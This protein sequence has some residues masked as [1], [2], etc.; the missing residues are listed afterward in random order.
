MPPLISCQTL[1]KSFGARALFTDI[2]FGVSEDEKLGLIGPNGSGKSTM[3]RLLAGEDKPD[4]GEMT[5][6]RGLRLVYVAQEDKFNLDATVDEIL[7]DAMKDD[8]LEDYE[9]D[10]QRNMAL[11]SAGF[12]SGE[13][14]VGTLSGGWKKRLSLARA[15]VQRPDLLLLDEPTNHLDLQG[16][17][18]L[19]NLLKTA[20]FAFILVSHDRYFL[21]NVTN[22]IVEL[23]RAYPEGYLSVNGNYSEFL[24]QK[25]DFLAVQQHRQHALEG[26]V[27]RE[28]DWLRRGP[29]ARTTKAQY[30]IDAA[31]QLIGELAEVKYRNAQDK[32][33]T[34]D[35]SAS[36]RK[37]RE[38][39]VAKKIAKTLGGRTLFSDVDI[40]LMPGSKL[41]L[42][43]ANGSGKTTLIK[44]LTGGME[45][46]A[47]TIKRADGLR[48]VLFDQNR[49]Q[50]NRTEALRHALAPNSDY[51]EFNG[52]KIHIVSW[53]KRFLFRSQQL[54][55]P[56][57]SL[58]GGEQA[59][60]LI[61]NLMLQPAD[62]LILDEPTND[63]DIPS[64]EVLEESLQDFKGALLLVTHDR[65]ML[66]NVSNDLLA[67]DGEGGTAYFADY[68]QWEQRQ[69]Q[70]AEP[71][72]SKTNGGKAITGPKPSG[73]NLRRLNSAE[74]RELSG[75]EEK[76][77]NA[78]AE[79]AKRQDALT[80]PT[81]FSDHLKMQDALQQL[82]TMQLH[83]GDLYARWAELEARSS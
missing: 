79:M 23:N 55:M 31:H 73:N 2:S 28:I 20:S 15:L 37:T 60:I 14:V 76:I 75:M 27:K 30:R 52:S 46:D 83:V 18:W 42:I 35:F 36:G 66:D 13:Q 56:V 49:A 19:E 21:E 63:L 57:G 58:S 41:G 22:R 67:L 40:T 51:V 25:E 64:L 65:Y 45:P 9:R 34:I 48:V 16:V 47:G 3:M 81:V 8:R 59:R 29:Q 74:Q 4:Q 17:L 44:L 69:A 12:E 7:Y 10:A 68:A 70:L 33:A 24:I 54:D 5:R 82:E 80:D 78:E 62:L 50:L 39:L 61:A 72:P 71:P 43:G 53:A 26:Q 1:T 11:D 77:M 32:S 6:R 38:L